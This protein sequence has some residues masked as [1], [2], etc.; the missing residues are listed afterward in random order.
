M[1]AQTIIESTYALLFAQD[2][3]NV[4]AVLDGASIPKLLAKLDEYQPLTICLFPE[5]LAPDMAEV[6]PY[7]I[8]LEAGT[9]FIDWLLMNGWGEH[10]G[11]YALTHADIYEMRQH[12]Y[13][14]LIVYDHN[15]KPLR[16]RYY[17]PRVL[18]HFLPTCRV[19]ELAAF[20]GPI[21]NFLLEAEDPSYLLRYHTSNSSLVA[22][23]LE[24]KNR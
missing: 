4:Y 21:S 2:D 20:F 23:K 11:I 12:L 19:D 7:L 8:Q 24:L 14:F 22:E 1:T 13:Q 9:E 17:D 10:W 15:G 3:I 16:F 18:R 6:A 5:E